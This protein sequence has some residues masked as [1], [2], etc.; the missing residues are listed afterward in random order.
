M[1][2]LETKE[3]VDQFLDDWV[4]ALRSG[5]YLQAKGVLRDTFTSGYCCLGV[6]ADVAGVS[7]K[8][9]G[10]DYWYYFPSKLAFDGIRRSKSTLVGDM[11]RAIAAHYPK[12]LDGDSYPLGED[13]FGGFL[14]T[15]LNDDHE[16]NFSQIADVIE[17]RRRNA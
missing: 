8:Q 4:A 10:S 6:A 9:Q 16:L 7:C 17:Y 1:R 14:L 2:Q 5:E 3:Q 12:L 11:F 13:E 15:E